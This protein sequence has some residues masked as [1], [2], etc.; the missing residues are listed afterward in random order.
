MSL[1]PGYDFT[2]TE[3]VTANKLVRWLLGTT[4]DSSSR[5]NFSVTGIELPTLGTAPSGLSTASEGIL[6]LNQNTGK[7]EVSTRWGM[8]PLFGGGMF[9]K[10]AKSFHGEKPLIFFYAR[11]GLHYSANGRITVGSSPSEMHRGFE[12]KTVM[13]TSDIMDCGAHQN[14]VAYGTLWPSYDNLD[15][16]GNFTE[17]STSTQ[18]HRL[19]CLKGF[20]PIYATAVSEYTNP[21]VKVAQIGGKKYIQF[22]EEG[23]EE[24]QLPYGTPSFMSVAGG[25]TPMNPSMSMVHYGYCTPVLGTCSLNSGYPLMNLRP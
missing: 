18:I 5:L 1:I 2:Q 19:L 9:T 14:V 8:V 6:S 23:S 10:R 25:T 17:V 4:V 11:T 13:R 7:I 16:D 15:P 3:E 12:Y 21:S 22:T 24:G 20:T